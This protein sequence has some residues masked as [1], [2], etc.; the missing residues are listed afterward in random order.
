M[1]V[2]MGPT[3]APVDEPVDDDDHGGQAQGGVAVA[4]SS[5][6]TAA[7]IKAGPLRQPVD[8]HRSARPR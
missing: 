6:R 8:G 7:G 3:G 2:M 5:S 1:E 4:G